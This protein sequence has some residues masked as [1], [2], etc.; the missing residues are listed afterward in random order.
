MYFHWLEGT[1]I[2]ISSEGKVSIGNGQNFEFKNIWCVPISQTKANQKVE[3]EHKFWR[4]AMLH[5][6][7]EVEV[8]IGATVTQL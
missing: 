6:I 5:M 1:E 3:G 2:R 8:Y 4:A 7:L